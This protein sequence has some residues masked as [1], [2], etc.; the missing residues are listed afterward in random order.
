MGRLRLLRPARMTGS[1]ET[2]ARVEDLPP[3]WD[4]LF[5]AGPDAQSSRAWFTATAEAALPNGARPVLLGYREAGVPVALLPMQAGPGR[6]WQSLTTPY[7]CLFQPLAAPGASPD[8]I[9][10]SAAAFGL[11]GRRW[12]MMVLE[13]IDP[14]WPG[15]RPFRA[16]LREAGVRTRTF[17][18]FGNW[19]E[20][21]PAS[22]EAY[23]EA[24]PGQLRATIKRK[25]RSA[26]R[27][28]ALRLEFVRGPA[29]LEP[30]LDAFEEVYRRSWKQPEPF[31]A[32]NRALVRGLGGVVRFGVMW[33]GDRP[34]AAQYWT[35][36]G[37]R[38]TVLK[39]AHDDAFSAVSPGTVL[40]A[41]V[42][43]QLMQVEGVRGID[44]GRGDDGYKP[45]WARQR[46]Q[47]IGLLGFSPGVRGGAGL[48]RHDLG[49][50]VRFAQ[51]LLQRNGARHAIGGA[52]NDGAPRF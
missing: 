44:F 39:L 9:R 8:S 17:L 29:G 43:R 30:A 34:I 19:Y 20:E 38:A 35:A 28:P 32:F 25:T 36:H 18:H 42:I 15:L 49:R 4:P 51:N 26:E 50:I 1:V 13:A 22:W 47:R 41:H 33:A 14:A 23:V 16:G 3:D 6:R 7:P 40:T 46:R 45:A 48:L 5:E 52:A 31:P 21:L 27:D 10:R 24:R 11:H 37:G 2:Y 12:P